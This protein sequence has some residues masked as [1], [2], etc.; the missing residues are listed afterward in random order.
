MRASHDNNEIIYDLDLD[1]IKPGTI[2]KYHLHIISDGLGNP[3]YVPLIIAKGIEQGPVFGLTAAIHGNE[4]NGILV[5]HNI[6][7]KINPMRLKGT[8]IGVPVSN[9]TGFIRRKRKFNDEIDLNK[10]MPGNPRGNRSEIYAYRFFSKIIKHMNYLIDLHTASSGRVNSFYVRANMKDHVTR[11]MAL[12]QN[13]EIILHNIGSKGTLRR[14]A[15]DEKIKCITVELGNPHRFQKNMVIS[16]VNGILNT[17]IHLRMI[18]GDI[19]PPAQKP[20]ICK[21]SYWLYTTDGG[22]LQVYLGLAEKV[23]KGEEIA[24]VKNIFGDIIETYFSPEDGIIIG[25][26]IDPVNQ[27]GSRILHLGIL[28]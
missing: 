15:T 23:K 3:I 20:V 27:T 4:L 13:A 28:K 16:S 5:I 7:K 2:E 17:F 22:V 10:I 18:E 19:I 12:L 8:I 14:S 24:K 6:I 21:K 1:K 25:K 11:R 26:S 9:V